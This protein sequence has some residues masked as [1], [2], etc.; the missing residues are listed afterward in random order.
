MSDIENLKAEID[1][2]SR[3]TSA[4]FCEIRGIVDDDTMAA[5][6]ALRSSVDRCQEL[7]R[8]ADVYRS[9]S[10]SSFFGKA[11]RQEWEY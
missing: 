1:K 2:V 3:L 8:R 9:S 11:V 5:W 10:P 4:L 6:H 7:A